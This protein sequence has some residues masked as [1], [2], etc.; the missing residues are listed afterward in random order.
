MRL[1]RAVA[2][3]PFSFAWLLVL[4]ITTRVQRSAGHRGS[5]RIQRRNSTNLRQLRSEPHRVLTTSLFWL[6]DQR[7]W[8]YVP[9]FVGVV[10]PAER[11]LG[12]WRWLLVGIGAHVVATYV[13]QSYLR[14]LIRKGRAPQR[15]ENARDVGVSYFVLGVAG[16]LSGY[17]RKPWRAGAQAAAALALAGNAAA[18]PTFTE[19]GHLTAFLLGLATVPLTPD[20]DEQPYPSTP[21]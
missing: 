2:G 15:A 11:R 3:A 21:R 6:D 4:L 5:R 18:R 17:T 1:L 20:R 10:A 16:A 8:P 12:W 9:V 19:V 7:W 14:F 13:G